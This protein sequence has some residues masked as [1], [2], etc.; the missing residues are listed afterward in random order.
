MESNEWQTMK[1]FD[2][3]NEQLEK[4]V[5]FTFGRFN[6]PTTGHEKLVTKVKRLAGSNPHRIYVSLKNDTMNPLTHKDKIRFMQKAFGSGIN[7]VDDPSVRDAFIAI[8]KMSDEGFNSF[9]FVVGSDRVSEFE[10]QLGNFMKRYHPSS[11]LKIVSAGDRDPD[12]DDVSGMSASKMRE[13]AKQN[14]FHSFRRGIPSHM[15][16]KDAHDMFNATRKGIDI[17]ES[18]NRVFRQSVESQ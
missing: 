8:N 10:R 15:S 14:D 2:E 9:V 6:P 16:V 7:V 3:L 12:A 4:K 5:F 1:P 18:L 17:M 11:K 13:F